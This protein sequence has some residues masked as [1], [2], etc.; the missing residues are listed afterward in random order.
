MLYG[1]DGKTPHSWRVALLPYN[2]R[3]DMDRVS[4]RAVESLRPRA[5]VFH[6]WDD[7]YPHFAPPQ[8]PTGALPKL[9]RRF[10]DVRFHVARL[11]EPI[12]LDELLAG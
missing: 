11:A 7:F 4:A 1:P 9:Q 2:G 3:T 5:V 12:Q 10:G 8:D 6:H